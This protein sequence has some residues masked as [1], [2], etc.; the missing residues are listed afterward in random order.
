MYDIYLYNTLTCLCRLTLWLQDPE[1]RIVEWVEKI[2]SDRRSSP[3]AA[4]DL[5]PLHMAIYKQ[6]PEVA[7]LLIEKGA[8]VNKKDHFGLT[9]FMLS[10]LRSKLLNY[11]HHLT[12][13]LL[14]HNG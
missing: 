12:Y 6:H 2:F 3:S 7:R 8:D 9:P 14:E 11:Y 4:P 13:P 10:A 1:K 5:T